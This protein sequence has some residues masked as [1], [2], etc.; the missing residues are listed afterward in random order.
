MEKNLTPEERE[1][2]INWADDENRIFIYTT[3]KKMMNK[4][5]KNPLFEM[6]KEIKNKSYGKTSVGIEGYLPLGCIT[7]RKS[8]FSGKHGRPTEESMKNLKIAGDQ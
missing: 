5:R 3:Q 6:T 1:T 4:L 7:I 2:L 8:L